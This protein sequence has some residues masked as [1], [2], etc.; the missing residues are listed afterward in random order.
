MSMKILDI[1]KDH[2]KITEDQYNA[3]AE[4]KSTVQAAKESYKANKS[5]MTKDQL[6]EVLDTLLEEGDE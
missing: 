2:G 5:K 6:K 3:A 4:R 1:L